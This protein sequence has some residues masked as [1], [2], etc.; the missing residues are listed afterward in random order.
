[1]RFPETPVHAE[2]I[3][4][5]SAWQRSDFPDGEVPT[6]RFPRAVIA[7]LERAILEIRA[8]G[9][10]LE[11]VTPADFPLPSFAS[12]AARLRDELTSGRGFAVLKG[13][14]IDAFSEQESAMAY[15]GLGTFFGRPL[16]QNVRG[17]RLYSVRDEGYDITRDYGAVGVRF[18]KTTSALHFHTDSAPALMGDTPDVVGLFALHV[19]RAGGESA[20]V[21]A[22]TA[23]NVFVAERPDLLAR[24]YRSY[25]IDRHAELRP[26]E[27]ATLQA[28]V[29][30][31]NGGIAIRYFR[32]YIPKG[33][34]AAG[35]ALEA[36]DIKPLDY[37]DSITRRPELQ[38]TFSM[39][40]GDIQ[41]V[42]NRW[43]LHSRTAFE[44]HAE[45]ARRRHLLRLWLKFET[46][47]SPGPGAPTLG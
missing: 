11:D 27:S 6:W 26:G 17:E 2:P 18:S 25:H 35:V 37:L 36:Q 7:E 8:Q 34:E 29:F 40:R 30:T 16:P 43:I 22:V 28:P 41:L 39:E 9:K 12:H 38:V 24:L 13:F 1:M 19:A 14:P 31:W 32:F 45:P 46:S 10:R 5:P 42:N 47:P 23:H 4:G 21:S 44:D 3:R 15:W 20:L 33:H